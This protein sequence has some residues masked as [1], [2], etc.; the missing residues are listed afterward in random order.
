M[1]AFADAFARLDPKWQDFMKGLGIDSPLVL[2]NLMPDDVPE[3][4]DAPEE[5]QRIVALSR[6][7]EFR[8]L[9]RLQ[10]SGI[11][12]EKQIRAVATVPVVMKLN[13]RPFKLPMHNP[14]VAKRLALE[15]PDEANP[16]DKDR[17]A[18]ESRT[19]TIEAI[20]QTFLTLGALGS[21]W[22]SSMVNQG[23][24][25]NVKPI[26][27]DGWHSLTGL[28]QHLRTLMDW[29]SFSKANQANWKT[30][31]SVAIRVFLER[32]HGPSKGA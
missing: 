10:V 30:P 16:S 28:E 17:K 2:A 3:L 32:I 25:E 27:T 9:R 31:D 4:L 15:V 19:M 24:L 29:I 23:Y 7:L 13:K 1:A 5:V 18:A 22:T 14:P 26:L 20:W 8:D 21:M 6:G 11:K 12:V